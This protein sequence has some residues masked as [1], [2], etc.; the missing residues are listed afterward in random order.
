MGKLCTAMQLTFIKRGINMN[1]RNENRVAYLFLTPSLIGFIVLLLLPLIFSLFLSFTDW[2]LLSGFKGIHFVGVKNFIDVWSDEW[3]INSF[4][5]N[6]Y[7]S[8][9]V[10]PV[11]MVI[12]LVL[13]YILNDKVYGKGTIRLFFFIPYI[14]SLIAVSVVFIA[15][16]HPTLGPINQFLR[17][18]GIKN[19]P[20][21]LGDPK[22]ALEGIMMLVIWKGL[23]YDLIIYLAGLQ[24]I[25]KH[26]YEAAMIDGASS[27]RKFIHITLPSLAPTTFFL[28][29]TRIIHSF[30]VFGPINVMTQGGPSQSTT[31]LVYYIYKSAFSFYKMG[32]AS[33]MSWILFIVIFAI[34]LVQ[35]QGQKKISY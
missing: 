32:Y 35:W 30:Q 24:N 18:L 25:P 16:Y 5:N 15:L 14:S 33:A 22:S 13:A 3:F 20:K 27:F 12:A 11:T 1:R 26:L 19:P 28:F 6:F 23:G 9:V 8:L 2:D 31:V 4:K 7:F 17:S 34:T 21:W 10:V 29:V